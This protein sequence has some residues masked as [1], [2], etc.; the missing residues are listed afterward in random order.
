MSSDGQMREG[1]SRFLHGLAAGWMDGCVGGRVEDCKLMCGSLCS[2]QSPEVEKN[3][4]N[5]RENKIKGRQMLHS[6]LLPS[7]LYYLEEREN[8]K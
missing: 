5:G 1:L 7:A 6:F 8:R 3:F 2:P 4:V